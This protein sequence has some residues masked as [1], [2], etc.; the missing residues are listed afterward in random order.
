MQSALFNR[1][2]QI[3]QTHFLIEAD[4]LRGN[5]YLEDLGITPPEKMELFNL[6][7]EEFQIHLSETDE[8]NIRTVLDTVTVLKSCLNRPSLQPIHPYNYA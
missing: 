3:L 7:E 5:L 6:F 1:L 4:L 2:I 8:R